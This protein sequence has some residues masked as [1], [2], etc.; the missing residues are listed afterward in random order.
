LSLDTCGISPSALIAVKSV[1]LIPVCARP[2]S[3]SLKILERAA[4]AGVKGVTGERNS[5]CGVRSAEF[6]RTSGGYSA[7]RTPHFALQ[8][9]S[10]FWVL[11]SSF[12]PFVTCHS[13]LSPDGSVFGFAGEFVL[14]TTGSLRTG[15]SAPEAALYPDAQTVAAATANF[16]TGPPWLRFAATKVSA[17]P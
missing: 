12:M 1:L 15:G 13:S 17:A 3:N 9:G 4:V 5:E 7:F 2:A 8:S 6:S 11:A 14:R 10:G 16:A